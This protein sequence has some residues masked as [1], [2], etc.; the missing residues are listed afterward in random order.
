M[1]K[2]SDPDHARKAQGSEGPVIGS[3]DHEVSYIDPL[4]Q[5]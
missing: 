3:G 1:V 5:Q 2:V 4:G